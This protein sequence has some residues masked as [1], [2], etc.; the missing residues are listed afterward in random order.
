M[1]L[2]V[3]A[4][5]NIHLGRLKI[6]PYITIDEIHTDNVYMTASGEEDDLITILTPGLSL[7]FPFRRHLLFLDFNALDTSHNDFSAEDTTDYNAAAYLDIKLGSRFRIELTDVYAEGHESRGSSATGAIEEFTVNTALITATYKLKNISMIQLDLTA[8]DW[9]FTTDANAFR[10]RKETGLSFYIYNKIMPKTSLF[11]EYDIKMFDYNAPD[12][13]LIPSV[14]YDND[15]QNLLLGLRWELSDRSLGILKAGYSWK[16]YD[17]ATL[18]S[19]DTWVAS[20]DIKHAFSKRTSLHIKGE[21]VIGETSLSGARFM[22]STGGSIELSHVFYTKFTVSLSASSYMDEFS[23]PVVVPTIE[24]EDDRIALGAGLL[25]DV[26]DWLSISADY[27]YNERDSNEAGNNFKEN[28]AIL[29]V[30]FRF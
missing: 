22:V 26:Q 18:E 2:S 3:E 5:G 24:R 19:Y 12:P 7:E 11:L 9:E 6:H 1:P 28:R 25:Y 29:G 13:A 14:E 30:A 8:S 20:L 10:E 15:T 16:E 23:D 21:R 17:S 27:S 4:S